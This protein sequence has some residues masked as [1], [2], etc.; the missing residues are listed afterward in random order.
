VG[1]GAIA[2]KAR[3][4][5]DSMFM[6]AAKALAKLSPARTN[7]NGNL[8][9]PVIALRDVSATVALAVAL[10]AH[11]EGLTEGI[12]SDEI[13]GLIRANVWAPRYLPYRRVNKP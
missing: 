12:D 9:P 5:T 6:A 11:N 8:L 4:V 2:V 1:L 3:R 13:E 10:Q 7:P